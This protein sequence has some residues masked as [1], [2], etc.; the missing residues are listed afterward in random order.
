MNNIIN[1][2][3]F[4]PNIREITNKTKKM[5]NKILAIEV[6]APVMPPKPKIAAIIAIIINII[7]YLKIHLPPQFIFTTLEL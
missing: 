2:Y 6:A 1:Y 3:L 7:E 5:K 4:F